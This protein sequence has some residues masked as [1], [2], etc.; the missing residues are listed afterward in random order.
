MGRHAHGSPLEGIP[1]LRHSPVG[2]EGGEHFC[3]WI[4]VAN[5]LPIH[6]PIVVIK[7]R[8]DWDDHGLIVFRGLNPVPVPSSVANSVSAS[9]FGTLFLGLVL[10]YYKYDSPLPTVLFF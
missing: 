6:F 5:L 1:F 3:H 8:I 10:F 7:E 9:H 2:V 4:Y